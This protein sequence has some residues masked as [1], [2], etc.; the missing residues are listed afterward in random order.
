M[1]LVQFIVKL[2]LY[3]WIFIDTLFTATM[4]S[5]GLLQIIFSGPFF[6]WYEFWRIGYLIKRIN[7][8]ILQWS[9]SIFDITAFTMVK[10]YYFYHTSETLN[11]DFSTFFAFLS[12]FY[13][14]YLIL[15]CIIFTTW[16]LTF[17]KMRQ[18]TKE[19]QELSGLGGVA[20]DLVSHLP[21]HVTI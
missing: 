12:Y 20:G 18:A 15:P 3:W 19:M 5:L 9:F 2:A 8:Y 21:N 4:T 1:R 13:I 14:L 16:L 10:C 7:M 11:T 17:C 6:V